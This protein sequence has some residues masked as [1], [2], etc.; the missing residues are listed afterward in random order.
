LPLCTD[1]CPRGSGTSRASLERL[2]VAN[3][4]APKTVEAIEILSSTCGTFFA[5]CGVVAAI[6]RGGRGDI[7]GAGDHLFGSIPGVGFL[8]KADKI[9][10]VTRNRELGLAFERA[11]GIAGPKKGIKVDGRNLF[12]DEVTRISLTEVKNVKRLSFTRQLRDYN[13]YAKDTGRK[14]ILVTRTR[15]ISGPLQD[16]IDAGDIIHRMR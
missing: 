14:F 1:E 9:A 12:P 6:I 11:L 16:A 5:P 7:W 10:D 3:A 15:R 8:R 13:K 4:A 2:D